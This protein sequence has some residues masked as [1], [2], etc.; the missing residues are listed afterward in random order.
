MILHERLVEPTH[1]LSQIVTCEIKALENEHTDRKNKRGHNWQT[2]SNLNM[3][4][5]TSTIHNTELEETIVDFED[6]A[7]YTDGDNV[8]ARIDVVTARDQTESAL[9]GSSS[10]SDQEAA[11][12]QRRQWIDGSRHYRD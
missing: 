4:I 10:H 2:Q 7:P 6:S 1:H 9:A 12:Q 8:Q 3:S 11:I 5:Y